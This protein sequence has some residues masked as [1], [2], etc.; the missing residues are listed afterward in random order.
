[1]KFPRWSVLKPARKSCLKAKMAKQLTR[2]ESGE[3]EEVDDGI[4]FFILSG[5]MLDNAS[6]F[7]FYFS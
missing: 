1:M 4:N 3:H 2:I 7:E 5:G 6:T